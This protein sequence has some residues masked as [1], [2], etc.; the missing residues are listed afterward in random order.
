MVL[1]MKYKS[2]LKQNRKFCIIFLM[3]LCSPI[4]LNS[5]SAPSFDVDITDSNLIEKYYTMNDGS[6]YTP[7]GSTEN[8]NQAVSI[9]NLAFKEVVS[10][11]DFD[12]PPKQAYAIIVGVSNYPGTLYDLMYCRS[13]AISMNTM[14]RSQYNFIPENTILLTD[15]QATRSAIFNAFTTIKNQIGSDDI[16][17]FSFSG[18]GGEAPSLLHFICPYDSLPSDPNKYIFDLEL[19]LLLDQLPCDDKIVLIDACNSGGFI[20]EVQASN[21]F[22]MTACQTSQLSWE[23]SELRHGVFTYYFIDSIFVAPDSNGDDVRS[24][25]EQ[26]SYARSKT[27]SYMLGHGELQQP[28]LYDGISG[29]AVLFPSIGSLS[30]VPIANELHYSFYVYGHGLLNCLNIT[31]CSVHQNISLEVI[32]L[33]QFPPST[34]GFGYYSG[35]IQLEEGFNVSGYEIRAE[36]DGYSLKSIVKTFG[37]T[38]ND[39][40]Y[41]ILEITNGL[42]PVLNDTDSDGLLDGEEVNAYNTDPLNNDTDSDGLFDGEEVNAYNTN[43]LNND[44]DSDGLFDGEEVNAY[45]TNPLNNDTDSDGLLDGEEVNAYNTNPLNDDTD[46]DG[47]FDEEEVNAYN[48]DPLNDD[49]D[50]D[51]L[52][53]G[54]EVNAYNTNPLNNDTDSDGLLDGEEVNTYNTDP[55]S[56]DT[57]EDGWSDGDEVLVYDTDPL[58]PDDHP[59]PPTSPPAA[60]PGYHIIILISIMGCISLFLIRKKKFELI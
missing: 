14:L 18:H 54:E 45:N 13:D 47:L 42:N 32:D 20:S 11:K 40:L 55:L 48:T 4:S 38:D 36:I 35:I 9:G 22:I 12:L 28:S 34:T 24:L 53:D 58:D 31:V 23:T 5:F 51:G 39:G 50:S 60:I 49:T 30:L 10:S 16:F 43:P 2:K 17:F 3:C 41:D 56:S 25:E 46:S 1:K 33:K 29:Q 8:I 7:T 57:D 19:D 21:R 27:I 44:T 15:S 26:F 52:L 6:Q 59:T 37:D